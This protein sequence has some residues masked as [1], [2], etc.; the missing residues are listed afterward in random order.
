MVN[1]NNLPLKQIHEV[2]QGRNKI[3]V[4]QKHTCMA[5]TEKW[6]RSANIASAPTT[7]SRK[8]NKEAPFRKFMG[9]IEKRKNKRPFLILTWKLSFVG[10]IKRSL[11]ISRKGLFFHGIYQ[12]SKT[13]KLGENTYQEKKNNSAC[14]L[15]CRS[16]QK[17]LGE[18]GF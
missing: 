6:P 8:V 3:E 17:A 2:I 15:A 18:I 10:F 16:S 5:R 13:T 12:H 11:T 7:T 9:Q 1:Y 14:L 4:V